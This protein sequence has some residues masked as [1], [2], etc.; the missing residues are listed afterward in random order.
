MEGYAQTQW[1][2]HVIYIKSVEA[3]DCSVFVCLAR[4]MEDLGR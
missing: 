4:K 1:D 3:R 2:M